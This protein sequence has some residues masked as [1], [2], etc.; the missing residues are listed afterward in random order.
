MLLG[1]QLVMYVR[2]WIVGSDV[3]DL[4][5]DVLGLVVDDIVGFVV[6]DV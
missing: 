4:V 2:S 3:V 6:C 1:L 5:D